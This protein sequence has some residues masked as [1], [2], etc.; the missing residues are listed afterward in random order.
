MSN[1]KQNDALRQLDAAD[2]VRSEFAGDTDYAELLELFAASTPD[3][4]RQLRDTF[5]AGDIEQLQ[6]FAHELK[7]A[8]GGYG[9]PG[10]TERAARLEAACK[11]N[12]VADIDDL[13]QDVLDFLGRIDV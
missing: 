5:R 9:F 1:L 12:D 13:L 7:G 3:K 11:A 2:P 8:G 4:Q 6:S 10:L